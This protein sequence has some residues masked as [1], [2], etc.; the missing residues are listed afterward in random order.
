[1]RYNNRNPSAHSILSARSG[2]TQQ[3]QKRYF[4]PCINDCRFCA[5]SSGD[6][7]EQKRL[8]KRRIP[9]IFI[10]THKDKIT[11]TC[12]KPL[13]PSRKASRKLRRSITNNNVKEPYC[14]KYSC[15][16]KLY[17]MDQQVQTKNRRKLQNLKGIQEKDAVD[18]QPVKDVNTE[19]PNKQKSSILC[20]C[21]RR[22]QVIGCNCKR[23][24]AAERS[25]KKK[26]GMGKQPLNDLNAEESY[27]QE[28]SN[29]QKIDLP[30]RCKKH[31]TS[32]R[33]MSSRRNSSIRCVSTNKIKRK[34]KCLCTKSQKMLGDDREETSP[35]YLPKIEEI[36][37]Y[38][39]RKDMGDMA[40]KSSP[41]HKRKDIDKGPSSKAPKD[42]RKDTG[43]IFPSGWPEI[44]IVPQ[45]QKGKSPSPKAKSPTR[46][47]SKMAEY[48]SDICTRNKCN[49]RCRKELQAVMY[50]DC[51]TISDK[52]KKQAITLHEQGCLKLNIGS[53]QVIICTCVKKPQTTREKLRAKIKSICARKKKRKA[54]KEKKKIKIVPVKVTCD[55]CGCPLAKCLCQKELK[56]RLKRTHRLLMK[57]RK[58]K[59]K[60]DKKELKKLKK[61][62]DNIPVG[63]TNVVADCFQ[64]LF[65]LMF[66]G[67]KGAFK[68]LF[69]LF[70]KPT[71]SM[72]YM[73]ARINEPH[74][75]WKYF[76]RTWRIGWQKQRQRI[77]TSIRGSD[78]M[79]ILDDAIKDTALYTT[80]QNKGKTRQ[81]R[82]KIESENRKRRRRNEKRQ[83]EALYS[84]R[85]M[86]LLTLRNRP[87]LWVYYICPY[88]YPQCL[89]LLTFWKHFTDILLFGLAVL[90]WTPCITCCEL[91][92]G[93]MC[94]CLCTG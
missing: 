32:V 48:V 71:Q 23:R 72:D 76:S 90:V 83:N 31:N 87:C 36:T 5:A 92:R 77:A 58:K 68:M 61:Q 69:H 15:L 41:K 74:A 3:Q 20:R 4:M 13:L 35:S 52:G 55:V 93:L 67:L 37:E 65:L 10:C 66:R 59:L 38:S 94:C 34:I 46:K 85:H 49:R 84:C 86:F 78:S 28:T 80:F 50:R 47:K 25:I 22:K 14:D 45:R 81:E 75:T 57:Q 73:K 43:E 6:Q 51:T 60:Q 64:G 33:P 8:T 24:K 7:P 89:S 79:K 9:N 44:Q 19:K 63:A 26:D 54:K 16:G 29:R 18:E 62:T 27:K 82:S 91:I 21:Y 53:Q 12:M 40:L 17:F 70:T 30:C 42:K 39:K 56:K 88:L 1:M 2:R 11:C